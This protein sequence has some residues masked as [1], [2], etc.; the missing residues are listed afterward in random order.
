MILTDPKGELY[1]SS[2]AL[3]KEKGYNIITLNF[4][5][6]QKGNAWNPM[7]LPYKLYK[8]GNSK[9]YNVPISKKPYTALCVDIFTEEENKN[10]I[11]VIKYINKEGLKGDYSLYIKI[12]GKTYN[13]GKYIKF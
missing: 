2:A 4:R 12:D 3:L 1:E 13:T 11:E 6:P 7:T 8:E 5:D 9:I 10:G